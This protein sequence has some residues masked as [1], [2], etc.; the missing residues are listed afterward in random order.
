MGINVSNM[1]LNTIY[2]FDVNKYVMS[3][4]L[5][6]TRDGDKLK[7]PTKL[8][9]VYK[10]DNDG[11]LLRMASGTLIDK[12]NVYD[13]DHLFAIRDMDKDMTISFKVPMYLQEISLNELYELRSAIAKN[14]NKNK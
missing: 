1:P 6:E 14:F 3:T 2:R 5:T 13:Y 8:I 11:V 4:M 7:K 9:E 12:P 10:I